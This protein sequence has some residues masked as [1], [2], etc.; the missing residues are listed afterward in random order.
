MAAEQVRLT[1]QSRQMVDDLKEAERVAG[2]PPMSDAAA[3]NWLI[4]RGYN[5]LTAEASKRKGGR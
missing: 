1:E 4:A 3:V 2:R 5:A